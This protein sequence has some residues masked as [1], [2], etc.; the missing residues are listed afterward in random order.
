MTKK[1][2]HISFAILL[3]IIVILSLVLAGITFR[4]NW[5]MVLHAGEAEIT[6][7]SGETLLTIG[8]I[9]GNTVFF[10]DRPYRKYRS[11]DTDE[12][13]EEWDRYF[14]SSPPNAAM[15][16]AELGADT[17]IVVIELF[18]PVVSGDEISFPIKIVGGDYTE[19]RV[20]KD[21]NLFIDFLCI[22]KNYCL[23][24]GGAG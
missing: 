22:T 9:S 19:G 6:E 11:M 23:G 8:K 21:V 7:T 4:T 12:F 15:V 16:H 10:S 20:Y 3:S 5:L 24:G 14:A 13:I 18:S 2:T 17:E 1:T